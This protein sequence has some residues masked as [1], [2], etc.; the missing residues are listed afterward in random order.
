METTKYTWVPF[1][2]ELANKLLGFKNNR[3]PLVEFVYSTQAANFIKSNNGLKVEDIDPFTIFAIF[4]RQISWK[5]RKNICQ[6][7]KEFLNIKSDIP[8]DFIGIPRINNLNSTFFRSETSTQQIPLLW[9]LFEVAINN[10]EHN[11]IKLFDNLQNFKGIKWNISIGLYWVKPN[12]YMPLDSPSRE[13]IKKLG[14]EV[15]SEKELSGNN[16]IKLN[17]ILTQKN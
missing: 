17:K 9:Q 2:T 12:M 6:K 8:D 11:F 13:Y 10:D 5:N 14:F 16:Y 1:Y 4:N 15:F 7:F 3:K